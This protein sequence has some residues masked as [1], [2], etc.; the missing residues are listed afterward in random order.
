MLNFVGDKIT[1]VKSNRVS[2]V[3]NKTNKEYDFGQITVSDGLESMTLPC[4]P[5][6]AESAMTKFTR[7]EKVIIVIDAKLD[8]FDN[9]RFEVC[10]IKPVISQ[11]TA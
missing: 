11:K 7:G 8:N 5:T 1:F 2:G 10:D 3:S 4:N 6:V 9:V